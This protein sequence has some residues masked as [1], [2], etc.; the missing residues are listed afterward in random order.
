MSFLVAES[1]SFFIHIDTAIRLSVQ[2]DNEDERSSD[3][4]RIL[5]ARSGAGPYTSMMLV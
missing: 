4:G 1:V 5:G 3:S 2:A